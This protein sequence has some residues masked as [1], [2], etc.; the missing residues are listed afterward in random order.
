MYVCPQCHEEIPDR[1]KASKDE[2]PFCH[3]PWP[4]EET[5]PSPEELAAA[6]AAAA[7]AA[8]HPMGWG[9]Q[10]PRPAAAPSAAAA[11]PPKK[12]KVGMIIA[13]LVVVLGGGGAGL[14][15]GVIAKKKGGAAGPGGKAAGKGGVSDTE[16][17]RTAT[18]YDDAYKVV[19][20]YFQGKCGQY[21]QVGYKYLSKLKLEKK[22]VSLGGK[23]EEV[24]TFLLELVPDGKPIETPDQFS[25][26]KELVALHKDHTVIIEMDIW[27]QKST[28]GAEMTWAN[29]EVKGKMISHIPK[30]NTK[31]KSAAVVARAGFSFP[32]FEKIGDAGL[33]EF[34]KPQ[35]YKVMDDGKSFMFAGFKFERTKK[36]R[37]IQGGWKLEIRTDELKT[38][39]T[40]WSNVCSGMRSRLG[41][42][43]S[44]ASEEHA[45][46]QKMWD[47]ALAATKP[48]CDGLEKVTKGL[49]PLNDGEITAGL[50]LIQKSREAWNTSV[51][52]AMADVAAK[53]DF[54]F[55]KPKF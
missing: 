43:D 41:K 53:G 17:S 14:Y 39:L 3:E 26:P 51:H 52:Q 21:Q 7:Q 40:D 48:L 12:S 22:K 9:H 46:H 29:V 35:S 23:E 50:A 13:I 27:E 16:W 42:L 28:F 1:V 33:A 15:F 38:A 34:A 45:F 5:G 44:K 30:E 2:C 31:F 32:K 10:A 55:R 19:N 37:Y 6:E 54:E 49:E 18:W 36:G 4:P 24:S 8:A 11:E 25:C 20:D 47:A